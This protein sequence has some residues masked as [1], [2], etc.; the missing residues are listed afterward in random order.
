[1]QFNCLYRWHATTSIQDEEWTQKIFSQLFPGKPT[2]EITVNDFKSAAAKVQQSQPDLSHW[3]FGGC[4]LMVII[5]IGSISFSH[6]ITRES[7]GSFK[8]D[9]LAKIL[10]DA[11]VFDG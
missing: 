11:Y 3:T 5:S 1:M 8:D 2:D 9:D 10:H 6:S 7:D 4:V